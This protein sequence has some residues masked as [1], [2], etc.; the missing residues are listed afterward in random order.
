MEA[1]TLSEAR[2]YVGTYARY[3]NGSLFGKWLDLSDYSDK[4]EFL[5]ACRELHKDEQ[6]P[7]Y[8]FQDYE[9][10]PES[11]IS[12]SWL[13]DKFFELRDAIEKLSET[14]QE[15]FF[16]WCDHHNCDISEED[17]DDL[18]SS[19]EDE[20]QGEYKDEE[21]YAYEIV[22]E[23]YDLPEFAKSYFDYAKFARDLFCGDYWMED[24]FVFRAA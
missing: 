14:E 12:E 5:E 20:Y 4:D 1:V 18:I 19:F 9:N 16:V 8:M 2:V 11:L 6:D 15:A 23:C 17:A 13:S 24:G 7:E 22:E 21:D 3:N 10:V